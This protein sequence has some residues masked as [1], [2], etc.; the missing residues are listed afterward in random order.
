MNKQPRTNDKGWS[1]WFGVWHEDNNHFTLKK[2]VTKCSKEP[3]NWIDTL[4]KWSKRRNMNMRVGTWNLRRTY[5]V[6]SLM[7]V[8][9]ELS[10][11]R[12]GFVGVEVIR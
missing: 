7:T 5:G 6:D 11:N 3:R 10:R 9:K 8:S 1:F 2:L 4:D 12:L